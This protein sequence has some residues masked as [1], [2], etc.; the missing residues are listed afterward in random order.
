MQNINNNKIDGMN[1]T[2]KMARKNNY[3]HFQQKVI[4]LRTVLLL[5]KNS[6]VDIFDNKTFL[7][8]IWSE[9]GNMTKTTY[10]RNLVM[11]LIEDFPGSTHPVWYHTK[12]ITNIIDYSHLYDH[13][14]I[15]YN[16]HKEDTFLL[17]KNKKNC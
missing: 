13:Y 4:D 3:S 17:H 12:S 9:I 10:T 5:R 1:F 14:K 8:N 11:K 6:T 7:R 15:T 16:N 2:I